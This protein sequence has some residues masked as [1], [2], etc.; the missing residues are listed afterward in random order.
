MIW[1]QFQKTKIKI[2]EFIFWFEIKKLISKKCFLF[3]F[4]LWNWKIKNWKFSKFVLCLNQKTNYTFG[5][6]I[7]KILFFN[8][9]IKIDNWKSKKKKC[10]FS[11]FNFEMKLK[12]TKKSFS[13]PILKWKLN[14]T[15]VARIN[16]HFSKT[17][18]N[19]NVKKQTVEKINTDNLIRI[20]TIVYRLKSLTKNA[21]NRRAFIS[22]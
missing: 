5:I 3:Q 8:F 9:Q 14:G 15:F 11:I 17:V 22:C 2:F 7:T 21:D 6:R 4:W 18:L 10:P 16:L 1:N 13:I 12:Y 20:V 19:Q